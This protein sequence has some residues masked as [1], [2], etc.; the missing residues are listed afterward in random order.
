MRR[1]IVEKP[2]EGA[3]FDR[4]PPRGGRI[5]GF[6]THITDGVPSGDQIEWYRR[7]FGAGGERAWDA[8]TDLVMAQDGEI[9][10]LND[11]RDPDWGGRR[12]GWANGTTAGLE[13]DGVAFYRR[14]PA[15]NEVLVSCEHVAKAGIAWTTAQIEATIELRTALA[16]ELRCPWDAYPYH[17]GLGGV[18]IEQTHTNFAAKAC[19]AEPYLSAHHREIVQAVRA[20][21]RAWQGGR[22]HLPPAPPPPEPT[23]T[24]FGFSREQVATYFGTMTRHNRDG[25]TDELPFDSGGVLSLLWLHRCEAEGRF[26]EAEELRI[27]A[28]AVAAGEA[29]WAT[30]EGGWTA[31]CPLAKGRAGWR[32]LDEA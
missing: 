30:W 29:W 10:L 24:R 3:G 20:K 8:L 21:L 31:W 17:P 15:I 19:P 25:T 14:F 5:A 22:G 2:G 32:W 16:Q 18:S 7:F 9:G 23:S 26:P 6:C 1:A 28:S 4:C 27:F 11:W 12:A 13:G